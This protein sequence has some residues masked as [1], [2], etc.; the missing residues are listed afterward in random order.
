MFSSACRPGRAVASWG[1]PDGG[2]H[3]LSLPRGNREPGACPLLG[4]GSS[5]SLDHQKLLSFSWCRERER[6]RV[7]VCVCV[8]VCVCVCV[9][10]SVCVCVSVSVF[11][12][13]SVSVCVYLC[14]CV[15]WVVVVLVQR[16]NL[17]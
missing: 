11:V 9:C 3:G 16:K 8:S 2:S 4:A 13:V 7:C 5:L 15:W 14:V 10:L 6:T 17:P 1:S 12:C